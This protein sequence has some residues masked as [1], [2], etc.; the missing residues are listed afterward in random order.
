MKSN[1]K[2]GFLGKIQHCNGLSTSRCQIIVYLEPNNR[3]GGDYFLG[4]KIVFG[5][6]FFPLC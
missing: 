6:T 2:S 1:S 3:V 5:R 4:E